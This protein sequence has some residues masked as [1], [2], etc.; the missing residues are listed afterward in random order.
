MLSMREIMNI[1]TLNENFKQHRSTYPEPIRLRIH[2]ALSWLE[3]AEKSDD[4]DTQF[5]F[6][7]I[8]FN[9]VYAKDLSS[10]IKNV[11][12]SLFIEFLYQICKYDQGQK[13]YNLIWTTYSGSI[14]VLLNNPYTFQPFWDYQN[15]LI[16]E[17]KWKSDFEKNKQ[18]AFTALA[19]KDTAK[20]L[21]ALFKHLYTLRNQIVH[22]GATYNS[23]VNRP[24][25]K[26]ACQILLHLIPEFIQI[27][28][29]HADQNW[30]KPFY[31]VIKD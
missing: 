9:A 21:L 24:Q 19:E 30:G 18:N 3:Q 5:I 16:D 1:H 29:N 10:S 23:S 13:I 11:D 8:A 7:W 12:K 25:I 26:D 15:G 14:R 27:I 22:G 2:R 28:L 20:I 17:Q 31:P 6:L 4:L